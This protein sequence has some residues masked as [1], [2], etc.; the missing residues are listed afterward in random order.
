MSDVVCECCGSGDTTSSLE[1]LEQYKEKIIVV[2]CYNC[3][4]S[5]YQ[6]PEEIIIKR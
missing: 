6:E 1:K 3:E 4:V 5:L 2:H